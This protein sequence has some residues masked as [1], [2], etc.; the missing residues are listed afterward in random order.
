MM[1]K[2]VVADIRGEINFLRNLIQH[3]G[4]TTSDQLI[5]TGSYLGPGPDSKAV[6]DYIIELHKTLPNIALLRGCYEYMFGFCVDEKPPI[7]ILQAWAGMGGNQ[8]FKSYATNEKFMIMKPA[9]AHANGKPKMVE[10]EM[11][12]R[13]PASHLELFTHKMYHWFEDDIYPFVVTHSGGHPILFGGA[14]ENE[15][16]TVFAEENW[17]EQTGRRIPGKTVIFSHYPFKTPFC[18]DGKLGI[19]LGAGFGGKL[20]CF[21]MFSQQ[22]YT[23]G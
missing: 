23:F 7:D 11:A 15:Q 8:V 3:L 5:F 1:R 18:K 4:P 22:F 13:I 17:W 2:F 10:A 19:D 9:P 12:L 14:M 20:C 16:Q 21:E 6:V